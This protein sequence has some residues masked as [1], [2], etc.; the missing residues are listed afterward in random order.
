MLNFAECKKFIGGDDLE[1]ES[2]LLLLTDTVFFLNSCST[3]QEIIK[4]LCLMIQVQKPAKT[5]NH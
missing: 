4:V 1:T 5:F 2:S 3:M